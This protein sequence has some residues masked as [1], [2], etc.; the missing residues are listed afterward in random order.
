[1]LNKLRKF[2]GLNCQEL[3]DASREGDSKKVKEL[4]DKGADVNYKDGDGCTPLHMAAV[5]GR[6]ET[7]AVLVSHGANIEAK[8]NVS[9]AV[10]HYHTH[11]I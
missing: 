3:Y 10:H 7:A 11:C 4:I 1:M 2:F 5:Y 6:K 8:N 9:Q